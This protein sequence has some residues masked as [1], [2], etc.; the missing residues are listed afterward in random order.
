MH[1]FPRIE[2]LCSFSPH[3]FGVASPDG[4]TYSMPLRRK[5]PTPIDFAITF[6]ATPALLRVCDRLLLTTTPKMAPRF[7]S[8]SLHMRHDFRPA[9]L[10][11]PLPKSRAISRCLRNF[12]DK[13]IT[14]T[15]SHAS[16]GR[17]HVTTTFFHAGNSARVSRETLFIA[18]INVDAANMSDAAGHI[19]TP[20][21]RQHILPRRH[22]TTQALAAD[23]A[24]D[25]YLHGHFLAHFSS[26]SSLPRHEVHAAHAPAF[27][28]GSR[29]P[30]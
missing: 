24:A 21:S 27:R 1:E 9:L 2:L 19:D 30:A 25:F 20:S 11:P 17:P 22:A 26:I 15:H 14:I 10:A 16:R 5:P 3:E 4:G 13:S 7:S 18:A 12:F 6:S 23:F 29:L 28:A 8:K